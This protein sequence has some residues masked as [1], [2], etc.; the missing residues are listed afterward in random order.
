VSDIHLG[1]DTANDVSFR[2]LGDYS[3]T[4]IKADGTWLLTGRRKDNRATM[5]SMDVFKRQVE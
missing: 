4:W 2:T 5:G 1:K 3:D